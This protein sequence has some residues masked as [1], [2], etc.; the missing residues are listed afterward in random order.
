MIKKTVYFSIALLF[1]ISAVAQNVGKYTYKQKEYFV[2]PYRIAST[3]DIPLLGYKM[4]DGQ[5]VVFATYNF[6][7]KPS[8]RK[9]KKYKLTDTTVVSGV[10]TLKNNQAEGAAI[11]YDYSVNKRGKQSK[12]PYQ[13]STGDFTGGLKTGIWTVTEKENAI[14]SLITHKNG[15]KDGY[16][17]GLKDGKI[18]QKEKYVNGKICDTSFYYT[19][20]KLSN[21]FDLLTSAVQAHIQNQARFKQQLDSGLTPTVTLAHPAYKEALELINIRRLF[22]T[23]YKKYDANGALILDLKFDNGEILPFDSIHVKSTYYRYR[24]TVDYVT[25]KDI[26]KTTKL[27]TCVSSDNDEKDIRK[28]YYKEEFLI[29]ESEEKYITKTKKRFLSKKRVVI[30]VDTILKEEVYVNPNKINDSSIIPVLIQRSVDRELGSYRL[31]LIEK[32]YLPKYKFVFIQSANHQFN[33]VDTTTHQIY[34]NKTESSNY[35]GYKRTETVMYLNETEKKFDD[36][37]Q[38][39]FMDKDFIIGGKIQDYPLVGSTSNVSASKFNTESHYKIS[40][41]KTF[42]KNDTLLNGLYVFGENNKPKDLPKDVIYGRYIGI[43]SGI[44]EGKFVNGK[45]EGLWLTLYTNSIKKQ[46]LNLRTYFFSHLKKSRTYSEINYKNGMY[47]GTYTYYSKYSAL[48]YNSNSKEPSRLYK[49][50]EMEFTRDTLNGLYKEY[51]YNDQLLKEVRYAMGVPDG[52]YKE[53][54]RSGNLIKRIN[55]KKGALDGIYTDYRN[56]YINCVAAF[57]NNL[58]NDSLVYYYQSGRPRFK[59]QAKNDTLQKK[60][61]YYPDGKTKEMILFNTNS[62][63]VLTKEALGSDSYIET[64]KAAKHKTLQYAEGYYQS[65]YDNGQLL[66][67]GGIKKGRL[68]GLWKFYSINGVVI[69]NVNFV[70]TSVYLGD[71]K[72]VS[73]ISGFYTGYYTTGVKRCDGYLK[74]LNLSYD[75]FTKQDKA[76]LDFYALNFFDING[77]QILKNGNGYYIKYESNGLRVSS[78]KLVDCDEDSLWRYYTPEQKLTEIGNYV[79]AEK[80]GVWYEGSLEGINFEDGACF[81][82]A[83]PNELKAFE[84]SRKRLAIKRLIYKDGNLIQKTSFDSN[85]NKTYDGRRRRNS[86]VS[87]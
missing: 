57:K 30:R 13:Q 45:K 46:P 12:Q 3:E 21:A 68:S 6:K 76:D 65:Y 24:P 19:N 67:E 85:L 10:V 71:C 60:I 39:P 27:L 79:D 51:Y 66:S 43:E 59:I 61:S 49:N 47:D 86:H 87:F 84:T 22:K 35:S 17:I 64:L 40:F 78:G 15:L 55:F 32:Y 1:V 75:C 5:Y 52:E 11:F 53:Y 20:G 25:V 4:P 62:Y 23:F 77:K 2:F 14:T 37:K 26:D 34:F 28:L 33:H 69:H 16:S 29:R 72:Y 41:N 70:D 8:L 82:M 63:S 58:L 73:K 36:H 7:V 48:Q 54:A 81:D 50:Y 56:G 18:Y 74:D 9:T 80:E 38:Q 31:P 83:N 44:R 42:Y